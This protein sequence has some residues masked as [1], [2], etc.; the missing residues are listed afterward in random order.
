MVVKVTREF[1][2]TQRGVGKPDYTREVSSSRERRGLSL[3]YLQTLKIFTAVFSAVPSPYAW[4]AGPLAIGATTSLIDMDTGFAMPFTVPSGYTLSLVDFGFGLTEDAEMWTYMGG[5]RI[6]SAG[7]YP[8]GNTY[9]ENRIMAVTSARL[10]PIGVL[11]L[12]IDLQLTNLGSGTL[13]GQVAVTALLEA[14]GTPPLPS[15]KTVKCKWCGYEHSVPNETTFITC[16]SCGKLFIL[17]D[18]SK[19]RN[20]P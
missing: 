11:L 4:V 6:L 15:T 9:Y 2:A 14:V 5:F 12:P 19:L 8:G 20:V 3:S 10:D 18:L 13:Q 1:T 7:V 16:P 17:Y